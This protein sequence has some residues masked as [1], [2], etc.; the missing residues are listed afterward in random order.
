MEF[1]FSEKERTNINKTIGRNTGNNDSLN[2]QSV[3]SPSADELNMKI[4]S[5]KKVWDA[6]SMQT[7]ESSND[8]SPKVDSSSQLDESKNK[9]RGNNTSSP[10][11]NVTSSN[12]Q[13]AYIRA[14][15]PEFPIESMMNA[16][17]NKSKQHQQQLQQQNVQQQQ[18]VQQQH[19]LAYSNQ[20]QIALSQTLQ[21]Q[22]NQAALI[23][24]QQ[25]SQQLLINQM[26]T[27]Q[28]ENLRSLSVPPGIQ[29]G[30]MPSISSQPTIMYNNPQQVAAQLY[31]AFTPIDAIQ[32]QMRVV[33]YGTQNAPNP[34]NQQHLIQQSNPIGHT[35]MFMAN[36]NQN[37][38]A[39]EQYRV[40]SVA[41]AHHAAAHQQ[42]TLANTL[43]KSQFNYPQVQNPAA[44]HPNTAAMH[45]NL[46]TSWTGT[47]P[48]QVNTQSGNYY[49]QTAPSMGSNLHQQQYN[50]FRKKY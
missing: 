2:I 23:Q 42:A 29:M 7:A 1:A 16:A 21:H 34:Y 3:T 15:K 27:R 45:H 31:Q 33:G 47:Q 49:Q 22:Q 36:H 40:N 9:N 48:G 38:A 39:A 4:A 20:S 17:M 13:S 14:Y 11:S 24:S 25:L 18:S 6:P 41:A 50:V 37:Q 19:N 26:G 10:L 43:L 46:P 35:N 8:D 32:N 28:L 5:V 44:M 12:S 30:A